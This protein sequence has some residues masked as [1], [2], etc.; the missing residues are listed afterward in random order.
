MVHLD[1]KNLSLM[2]TEC[3]HALHVLGCPGKNQASYSK[4]LLTARSFR[5]CYKFV[6]LLLFFWFGFVVVVVVLLFFGFLFPRTNLLSLIKNLLCIE[7]AVSC[8]LYQVSTLNRVEAGQYVR[9]NM[10]KG[11]C[12]TLSS[13][14]EQVNRANKKW[15]SCS[16]VHSLERNY[17][18]FARHCF[19]IH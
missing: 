5:R 19:K 10:K 11:C 15:F 12:E 17:Q 6:V 9:Y 4:N 14:A 1:G 3:T 2:K 8:L 13:K 18:T 7:I 16:S